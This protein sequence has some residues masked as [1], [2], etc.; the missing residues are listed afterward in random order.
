MIF[1]LK[2]NIILHRIPA[3]PLFSYMLIKIAG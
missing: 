2:Y 1:Y 3:I